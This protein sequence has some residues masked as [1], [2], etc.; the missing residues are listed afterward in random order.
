MAGTFFCCHVPTELRTN[1]CSRRKAEVVAAI[2]GTPKYVTNGRR[3][4]GNAIP[5]GAAAFLKSG[6]KKLEL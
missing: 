5:A 6:C 1:A 4:C 3:A 2:K